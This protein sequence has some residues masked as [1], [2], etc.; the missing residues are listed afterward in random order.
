M[1]IR[2]GPAGSPAFN[3]G[4]I[5][6]AYQGLVFQ[7]SILDPARLMSDPACR[8]IHSGRNRV[9]IAA[10]TSAEGRGEEVVIKEFRPRGFK[11][12]RTLVVA[13]PALKSWRGSLAMTA[14]GVA[15][16]APVAYFEK[17]RGPW[18]EKCFFITAYAGGMREIRGLYE[19][20]P[21]ERRRR[22]VSDL[23]G[24]LAA[25]HRGGILHRDLSDGNVLV[26]ESGGGYRFQLVDTNRVRVKRRIGPL[27]GVR[28]L[29]RLGV[30]PGLRLF[31]LRRYLGVEAVPRRY[32]WWYRLFKGGYGAFLRLKRRLR[33]RRL[34]EWLKIQ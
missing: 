2:S 18:L 1:K 11:R 25:G 34:A 30:P 24:F 22:L 29:I 26:A 33:L 20:L 5:A 27:R 10:L 14:A 8:I 15:T 28:N 32:L 17:R 23:A 9:G 7:P 31:F 6:P 13:S 16:P 4:E 12:L 3:R 21:E 19:P